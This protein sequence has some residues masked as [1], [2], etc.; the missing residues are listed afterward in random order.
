LARAPELLQVEVGGRDPWR[1]VVISLLL[2]RTTSA[3]VRPVAEEVFRRWPTAERLARCQRPTLER[4]LRPLG[5][6]RARARYVRGAS[7]AFAAGPVEVPSLPGCG[8][9]VSEAYRLVALGDTSFVPADAVLRRARRRAL[10]RS[11]ARARSRRE[12]P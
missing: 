5:L 2:V 6:W 12:S 4:V 10:R 8:R 9:Y 11:K 7:R 3:Q 1:V